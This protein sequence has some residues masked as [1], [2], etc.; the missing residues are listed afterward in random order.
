MQ[1]D[2]Q[3]ARYEA[4]TNERGAVFYYYSKCPAPRILFRAKNSRT[5]RGWERV[6]E[7]VVASVNVVACG[8]CTYG[9]GSARRN[10]V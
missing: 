1:S 9:L 8:G 2:S 5:Q 6:G 10:N 3:I 7:I 4:Q